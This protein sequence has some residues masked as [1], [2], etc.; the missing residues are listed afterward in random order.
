MAGK[1]GAMF[2]RWG[3]RRLYKKSMQM[4][5]L[6]LRRA[7]RTANV[8][9]KLEALEVAEQKLKDA[10]WLSEEGEKERFEAGVGEIQRT[11]TKTLDQAIAA[12]ERLLGGAEEGRAEKAEMLEAAGRILSYL[13]H[14]LPEDA[15]VDALNGR[16]LQLG[17]TQPAYTPVTPLSEMYVRPQAGTGCGAMMVLLVVGMVVGVWV[18]RLVG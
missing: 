10:Q 15:R 14:Y 13:N 3:E 1:S 17:G 5:V 12:V 8:L 2:Q 6:A 7:A 18:G 16:L 4:V 11:R 9:E